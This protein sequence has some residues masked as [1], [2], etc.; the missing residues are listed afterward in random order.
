MDY[1]SVYQGSTKTVNVNLT[2]SDGTP[3]NASGALLY[4]TVAQDYSAT[5]PFFSLVT[6]GLGSNLSNAVTGLMSFNLTTG[7]TSLCAGSYPGSFL[8]VDAQSGQSPIPVGYTVLP[9]VLP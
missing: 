3:Y 8:L 5:T 4:F 1:I 6:T 7:E 9:V 2:N